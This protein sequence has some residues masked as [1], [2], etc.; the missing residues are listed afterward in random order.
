MANRTQPFSE[1]INGPDDAEDHF[2]E[3]C[4]KEE[5]NFYD[6]GIKN[7]GF[8]DKFYR[9]ERIIRNTPDYIIMSKKTCLVEVKGF[10]YNPTLR[11]L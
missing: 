3:Y 9:V 4:K 5:I 8:G 6:Y 10:T 2:K 1:R 11:I 7:H